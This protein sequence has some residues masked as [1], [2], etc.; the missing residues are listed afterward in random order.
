MENGE[1][2]TLIQSPTFWF[3]TVFVS[4]LV[5]ILGSFLYD[6]AQKMWAIF[7][8]KQAEKNTAKQKAFD[9][10]VLEAHQRGVRTSDM[11]I[12]SIFTN[13]WNILFL[14]ILLIAALFINSISNG[15]ILFQVT[16]LIV[17]ALLIVIA[18]RSIDAA[19]YDRKFI[20]A[21]RKLNSESTHEQIGKE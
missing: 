1:I 16:G 2:S 13:L 14:I 9:N 7:S 19:S 6:L 21:V 11:E 3:A 12:H 10:L 17:W 20:N 4:L 15:S 18:N 8:K 5:S